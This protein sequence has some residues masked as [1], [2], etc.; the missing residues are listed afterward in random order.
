MEEEMAK[1]IYRFLPVKYLLDLF[2]NRRNV[3]VSPC[4]WDDPFENILSNVWYKFQGKKSR[5]PLGERAYGQCWTLNGENDASWRIYT[6]LNDGV[7]I[8]SSVRKLFN[9]FKKVHTNS[10]FE[11]YIGRVEYKTESELQ[12]IAESSSGG[13]SEGQAR[14]LC[15]KREAFTH[16]A[17]VRLLYLDPQNESHGKIY[18]YDIDVGE[19]LEDQILFDPRMEKSEFKTYQSL[20][21]KVGYTGNVRQSALYNAPS[22]WV[23]SLGV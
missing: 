3:L 21:G 23:V 4:C 15:L 9:G 16:E 11:C 5:Y 13:G 6:P 1:P 2:V 12:N 20:L 8:T 19:F 18:S 7:M 14:S 17:E 10:S 22:E